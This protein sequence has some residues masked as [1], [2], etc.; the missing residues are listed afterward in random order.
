MNVRVPWGQGFGP[1]FFVLLMSRTRLGFGCAAGVRNVEDLAAVVAFVL[2]H[3]TAFVRAETNS[4]PMVRSTRTNKFSPK[5]REHGA[6]YGGIARESKGF[7]SV[8]SRT[9]PKSF[10]ASP[11]IL[12]PGL[13]MSVAPVRTRV[14]RS[15]LARL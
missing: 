8:A 11:A 3:S 4:A 5:L 12:F 6:Y 7:L 1:A 15:D 13:F 9:Y 14:S 2:E 10:L